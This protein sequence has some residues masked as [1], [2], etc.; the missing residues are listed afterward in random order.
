MGMGEQGSGFRFRE[1]VRR[2][3]PLKVPCVLGTMRALHTV[4]G[5]SGNT[6]R[7]QVMKNLTC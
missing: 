4:R 2:L 6:D 5:E 1:Q 7:V 3:K